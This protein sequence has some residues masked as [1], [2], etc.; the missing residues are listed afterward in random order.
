MGAAAQVPAAAKK[1]V[2]N[3]LLIMI[4]NLISAPMANDYCADFLLLRVTIG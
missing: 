1:K 2:Y 4:S 3:D